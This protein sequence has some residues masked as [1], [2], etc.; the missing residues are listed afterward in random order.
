MLNTVHTLEGITFSYLAVDN[1]KL[2]WHETSV[3]EQDECTQKNNPQKSTGLS[4]KTA[5][6]HKLLLAQADSEWEESQRCTS[7]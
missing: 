2:E 1:E 7:A 3:V 4:T 6:I 5:E